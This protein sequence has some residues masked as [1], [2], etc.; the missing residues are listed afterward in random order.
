MFV[1]LAFAKPGGDCGWA[2]VTRSRD[3][4][5]TPAWSSGNPAPPSHKLRVSQGTQARRLLQHGKPGAMLMP[6]DVHGAFLAA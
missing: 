3:E 5:L 2:E 1:M 4:Q 6:R